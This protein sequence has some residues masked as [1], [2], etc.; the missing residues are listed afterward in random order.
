[1][2]DRII[3]VGVLAG[4]E[5]G[6]TSA[7]MYLTVVWECVLAGLEVGGTSAVIAGMIYQGG[8]VNLIAASVNVRGK[9]PG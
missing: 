5:V 2:L 8:D 7:V 4:L 6:G 9:V 1:M 3:L